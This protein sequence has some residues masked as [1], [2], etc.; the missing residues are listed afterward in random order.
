MQVKL[1][2]IIGEIADIDEELSSS[3][4]DES[5]YEPENGT[6]KM[7]HLMIVRG[8]RFNPQTGKEESKPYKQLFTRSEFSLFEKNAAMLGYIVIKVLY[9]P[10]NQADKMVLTKQNPKP[11]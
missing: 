3:V 10:Y 6:E 9:D 5:K 8:R 11:C 1:D 4:Q 2:E 7:V